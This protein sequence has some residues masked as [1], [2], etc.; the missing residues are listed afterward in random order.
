MPATS[1][2]LAGPQGH[3][4]TGDTISAI[5]QKPVILE[6]I[7]FPD[8]VIEVAVEPKT[9]AD[10]EKL[11]TALAKLMAAGGPVLPGSATT[12]RAARPSSR[13]GRACTW[14]SWSTA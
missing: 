13:D 3:D 10:Q 5:R 4:V 9:K 12:R 6:R 1:S 14:R 7:E 8:P 2:P 11:G